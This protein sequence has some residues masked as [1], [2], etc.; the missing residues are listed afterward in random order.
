MNDNQADQIIDLLG[1]ILVELQGIRTDFNEFTSHN[2]FKLREVVER[3]TGPSGYHMEDLNSRLNEV[4][5]GLSSVE[6]A[7]D[8]K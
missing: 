1:D 4:V 2:I 5:S 7:I 3:L 6:S 8:L